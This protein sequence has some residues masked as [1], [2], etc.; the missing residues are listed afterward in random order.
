MERAVL[1]GG[2]M[3][4]MNEFINLEKGD[5]IEYRFNGDWLETECTSDAFY[6]SDCSEPNWE[7]E[8]KNC[9]LSVYNDINIL[10]KANVTVG[11]FLNDKEKMSDFILISKEDFLESYSY[12]DEND[13]VATIVDI[14]ERLELDIIG[15][16]IDDAENLEG[17]EIGSIVLSQMMIDWLSSKKK[18]D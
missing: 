6:N 12:L 2:N 3:I 14:L 11:S 16:L 15:D 7:V 5:K 4:T 9:V 8:T 18:E 1:G 17:K 10:R 13:Y